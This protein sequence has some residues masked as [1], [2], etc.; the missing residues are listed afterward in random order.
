M[1]IRDRD[2]LFYQRPLKSKKSLI[3]NCPYEENHCLDKET[4]EIKD[5]YKRQGKE[6]ASQDNKKDAAP[7]GGGYLVKL[8]SRNFVIGEWNKADGG[9][10][11][12][13]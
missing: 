7:R 6:C 13:V 10:C 3:D 5:V 12:C 8:N 1:C 4:G 11:R 2:I 9:I